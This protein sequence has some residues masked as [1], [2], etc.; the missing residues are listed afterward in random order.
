MK[1]HLLMFAV[2]TLAVANPSARAQQ[3]SGV[4]VHVVVTV[5]AGKGQETPVINRE[6]VIVHEGHDR[7]EVIDWVP[8]QGEHA[9]LELMIL[10]DDGSNTTLGTQLDDIRNFIN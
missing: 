3:S 9:S 10:L 6:D 2:F 1:N 7:D 5:E 4:P 8:A